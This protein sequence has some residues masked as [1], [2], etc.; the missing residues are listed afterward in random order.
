[1]LI[2]GDGEERAALEQAAAG[3]PNVRFLGRIPNEELRRYYEHA[4]AAIMP[5]LGYE[6]FGIVLIEAFRYGTPVIARRI[7]PFPEIVSE[8][9]GGL[10]FSTDDELIAAMTALQRD[11]A[12]R[13]V[14]AESAFLACRD[15]W[16]EDVVI[17][18]FLELVDE[19]RRARGARP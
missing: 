16:S 7:G 12:R 13:D 3:A 10:L 11:S 2:I 19:A 14:Y 4:V 17:S 18:R 8:S 15:R 5:S 6:T 9:N 1:L